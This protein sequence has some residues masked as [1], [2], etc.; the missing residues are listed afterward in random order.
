MLV[1]RNLSDRPITLRVVWEAFTAG[2][3]VAILWVF[4]AWLIAL[5][6]GAVV[7]VPLYWA[8]ATGR[9][10]LPAVVPAIALATLAVAIYWWRGFWPIAVAEW[11]RV[12]LEDGANA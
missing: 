11:K 3:L 12:T 7:F 4:P 6:A 10:E 9:L 5:L 8:N 1:V 2:V